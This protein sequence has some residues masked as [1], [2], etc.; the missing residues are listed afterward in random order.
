MTYLYIHH[1]PV[2]FPS[3]LKFDPTRWMQPNSDPEHGLEKY[4]VPF[5]KG[6]RACVGMK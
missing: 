3:P 1:S 5:G 4:F 2:V 6:T